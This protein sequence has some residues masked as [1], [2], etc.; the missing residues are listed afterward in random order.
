[1][2]TLKEIAARIG[3]ELSGDGDRKITGIA[4]LTG[5]AEGQIAF[6][7]S[8]SYEKHLSA[9]GASA[10]IV[11]QDVDRS[12]LAGKNAIIVKNP[13]LAHALVADLF[14]VP[15]SRRAGASDKAFI[16]PS[17]VVSEE[18]TLY[19]Y[20][21]I[22]E[23]VVIEK[24][25]IIFPFS[26]VGR[27]V[28][29]GEGTVI[30]PNVS[31]YDRTVIGKRVIVHAGAVLGSDGFGYVWDGDKHKKIR[32]LGVLEI[33]DDVEIGANTCIDRASF[34]KTIIGKGTKIDN[35]V[36]IAHNVT[37]GENS[38]MVSQVG[39]AGSST[40]GRG[41]VLG[42][43]VGV[44][45]H[46]VIGDGVTAAGGTG[47]T[48]NVEARSIISGTP[49]MAHR[50]WLKLQVYLRKLPELFERMDRLERGREEGKKRGNAKTGQKK[51]GAQES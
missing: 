30:Y 23:G 17:A 48:K 18:S 44:A 41:V 20:A 14:D 10:F 49:H 47:I 39:I 25:V 46:V 7:L 31:I 11:G 19:P 37:V 33:G 4:S 27:N 2:I 32:Q 5:A 8:R 21:Y 43:K 42:G 3:G 50:D 16:A 36:Q 13:A 12:M 22:E 24:D 45:D 35:L 6:L 34:D 51:K 1:M 28:K 29:I 40:V 26:Y 38:I 9:S 15:V